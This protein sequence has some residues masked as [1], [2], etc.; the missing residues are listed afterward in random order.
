MKKLIGLLAGAVGL[1]ALA[2][3][4]SAGPITYVQTGSGSGTLGGVAFG[5]Q[6]PLSF[7]ITAVGDTAK[8]VSCG[9][10]CLSNDSVTA[11]ILILG[12]GTFD[13]TSA[14]RFFA[15]AS[16]S[17]IGFS[18]GGV[19]GGSDLFNL[20]NAGPYD[21]VSSFGPIIGTA[22]LVQW[23][24]GAV[25]TTGGVLV[26]NDGTSSSTFTATEGLG[27]IPEPITLSLFGAGLAGAI[28]TRRRKKKAA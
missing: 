3:G 25:V 11:S 28:A 21:M 27:K 4:A 8:V 7:T 18:R 10:A 22:S 6:A 2:G 19:G 14:T 5:L 13:F 9:V 12:L 23:N 17:A 1:F 26:F 20:M 15:N 24:D 16:V